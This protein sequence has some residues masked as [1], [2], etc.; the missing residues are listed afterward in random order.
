MSVSLEQL[1][2]E[3]G[4][5]EIL[6]GAFACIEQATASDGGPRYPAKTCLDLARAIVCR[7]YAKSIL[8]LAYLI[9]AA[10]DGGRRFEHLFW[11]IDRA[12]PSAFRAAFAALTSEAGVVRPLANGI[13]IGDGAD[14]FRIAYGRMPFLAALLE[15][16]I[17]ALGYGPVD[18]AAQPF[19]DGATDAATVSGVAG[20]WQR[21][22]YAYLKDHLPPV[23][24]QRRERHFL[25]FATARAGNRG[26]LDAIDDAA[27]MD[28]WRDYG[29]DGPVEAR[30]YRS[31]FETARRLIVVLEAAAVRFEAGHA[32]VVGTDREAGEIDPEAMAEAAE[33]LSDEQTPL[34][35]VLAAAGQQAKIV[36]AVE[37]EILADIPSNAGVARRLP[38]SVLRNGVYG[39]RQLQITNALRRG[40]SPLALFV[41]PA[42][43]YY[44][45][46]LTQYGETLSA[47]ER[48][49]LATLWA[50]F[51]AG[52][53]AACDLALALA[54]DLNWGLL[55]GRGAAMDD[56]GTVVRLAE[57]EALRRF[58][59]ETP[60]ARGD[61]VQ[62]FLADARK[63]HR[64]INRTGFKRDSGAEAI[65]A[66]GDAAKPFVAL[67]A[68]VRRF[69]DTERTG[70]D[71]GA[72]EAYDGAAFQAMFHA[73]YDETE[74]A[75]HAG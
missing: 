36:N 4:K 35:R 10:S 26:S 14:G 40:E 30:T 48:V 61:E 44:R 23:Q 12:A 75:A 39:A 13:E 29:A 53:E 47:L 71:W 57:R 8:E 33:L 66:M 45:D 56:E 69:V 7:S 70:R 22:L 51:D 18:E 41:P 3:E 46:R 5:S 28:Y 74:D 60:D 16:L 19:R 50:L 64:A 20:V 55:A 65:M 25:A 63:A 6:R 72:L 1:N 52:H 68:S 2:L 49:A 62:A 27:V 9:A 31:V 24:R 67:L 11:G 59:N 42:G 58:M 34:E 38:V 15:F 73:L 54:P 37:A 21:A 17:T 32:H 43:A